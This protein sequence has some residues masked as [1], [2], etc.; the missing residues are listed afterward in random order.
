MAI[1]TRLG[2]NAGAERVHIQPVDYDGKPIG[3]GWSAPQ[4]LVTRHYGIP[5]EHADARIVVQLALNSSADVRAYKARRLVWRRP[6]SPSKEPRPRRAVPY[7]EGEPNGS[8]L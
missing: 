2:A 5:P 6:G 3:S 1:E 4:D 8:H 7:E